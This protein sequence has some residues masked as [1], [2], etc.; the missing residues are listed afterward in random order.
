MKTRNTNRKA[1]RW[2]GLWLGLGLILVGSMGC[3][4]PDPD[5]VSSRPWNTPQSWEHGLPSNMYEGR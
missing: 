3:R 5:N 2:I 1:C 4:T